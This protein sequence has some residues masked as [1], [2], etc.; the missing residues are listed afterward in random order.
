MS[1]V[2]DF[3]SLIIQAA[4]DAA[5]KLTVEPYHHGSG[6]L[7]K[8]LELNNADLDR[9]L[10]EITAL[11]DEDHMNLRLSLAAD[12]TQIKNEFQRHG[13]VTMPTEHGAQMERT[14][15][16]ITYDEL[17][18]MESAPPGKKAERFIKH[19]KKDFRKRYGKRWKEVLYATAWK[20]FGEGTRT[21][22]DYLRLVESMNE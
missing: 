22:K 2:S 12:N 17:E 8:S 15:Q 7:I 19:Q 5:L 9:F 4:R 20:Q 13:F 18:F 6:A 14:P 16:G 3:V 10:I 1:K 11:A 21:F